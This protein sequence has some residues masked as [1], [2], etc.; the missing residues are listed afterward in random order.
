MGNLTALRN[1][2]VAINGSLN[3]QV[4]LKVVL[5]ET[6]QQL[7][8]DAACILLLA[9]HSQTLEYACGLGFATDCISFSS[10]RMG[11]G[12]AG[13]IALEQ[14]SRVI[15]NLTPEEAISGPKALLESEGFK[16]YA[17]FPL[18]AKGQI[19]GVLEV[20]HH[21][22]VN[23]GKDWPIFAEMLAGQAAIA[24]DNAEL[25][26]NLQRSHSELL[27]AYDTTIEGWSRALD[28]RDQ[29]TE[30]HSRRVTA[31][32]VRIAREMGISNEKLV[33][34]RRGSLLHDIGK[35]GVPDSI[36]LKPGTLTDAEFEIMKTHTEI[37]LN[38]LSPIEFLR[39]ALDI[40][41][42]H[43]EKWDGSGYPR[44]LKGVV[45]PLAARIFAIVD[46]CDALL[47]NRPYRPA[48]PIERVRAHIHSLSGTHFDPDI[49]KIVEKVIFPSL[50]E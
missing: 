27:L 3:L 23:Q 45:I 41:Y 48:W 11:E 7:Q 50:V 20:F 43:H 33:Q 25:Y 29:E 14:K 18:I 1:I 17:G 38:L 9:P 15:G 36:L 13:R 26:A 35:L 4:T 16:A 6:L 21:A 24:I 28:L 32:V 30:G 37:A 2:D 34:I 19:K 49:L 42:C 22:P 31:R 10:V 44:G 8:I 39:P 40:P 12:Y 47:S 46:V 5:T